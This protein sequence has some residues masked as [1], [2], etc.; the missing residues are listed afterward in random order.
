MSDVTVVLS[1]RVR[2]IERVIAVVHDGFVDAGFMEAQPSGRRVIPHYLT[3]GGAFILAEVDG[4]PAGSC[5][6]LPDGPWGLPSEHAFPEAVAALRARG[7]RL[8]EV[9]SLAVAPAHRAM[10]RHLVML[11]T[12]T[13][14]R[15]LMEDDV[16]VVSSIAPENARF[17]RGTFS[18][19]AVAGPAPLYGAPALLIETTSAAMRE[20]LATGTA[21]T[22][23]TVGM[24]VAEPDPDW[25]V[26]RRIEARDPLVAG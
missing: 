10:S 6:C 23:R 7:P 9:G 16:T 25:L 8:V 20:H 13:A 15:V 12:A 5:T 18:F 3:P 14:A 1:D 11:L 2:D 22:R 26:D 4:E 21:I 24:L 19:A 17:Y